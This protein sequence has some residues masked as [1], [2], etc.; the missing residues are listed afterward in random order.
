[1]VRAVFINSYGDG[2]RGL[3]PKNQQLDH[4]SDTAVVHDACS[5]FY[6]LC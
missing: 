2:D 4:Q 1:M 6:W 3:A 5:L